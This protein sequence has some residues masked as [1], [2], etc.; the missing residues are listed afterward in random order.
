MR[1]PKSVLDT[2]STQLVVD[3]SSQGDGVSEKL[4]RGDWVSED[5]HG[6]KDEEDIL[7]DTSKREDDGGCFA[8][9]SRSV[10]GED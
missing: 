7:E 2:F 3:K 4:K 6:R 8:N 5:D 10:S 1:V 9:L